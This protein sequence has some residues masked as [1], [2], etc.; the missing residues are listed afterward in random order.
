MLGFANFGGI[1]N[2][3]S[4]MVGRGILTWEDLVEIV[5]LEIVVAFGNFTIYNL[6]FG[7]YLWYGSR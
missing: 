1:G 5:G 6:V 2:F 4:K 7:F 3:E